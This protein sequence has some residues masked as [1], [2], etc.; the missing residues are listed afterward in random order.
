MNIVAV[1]EARDTFA[2]LLN[3]V[4]YGGE[5]VEIERHGKPVA[6]LVPPDVLQRL[7]ELEDELDAL[8]AEMASKEFEA[9][10]EKAVPLEQVAAELGVELPE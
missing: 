1:T 5:Q 8:K 6:V 2:D 3:R 7:E 9:S 10:G 4:A